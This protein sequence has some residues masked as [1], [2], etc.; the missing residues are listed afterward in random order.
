MIKR[1]SALVA[2]V[3]VAAVAMPAQAIT[4]GVPDDGAHPYVGQLFFYVPDEVDP[5]FTD[6]GSYFTCSGTLVSPTIVLT[7]GHCTYG[8]GRDGRSTI[9]ANGGKGG[10]DV[11]VSFSEVPD[12]DGIPLS[13][14]YVEADDNQGRYDDRVAWFNS[15][16][17][18]HR[19]RAYPHPE[20]EDALFFL[21]DLGVVVLDEPVHM[22]KYGELPELHYLNAF[23]RME[24]SQRRFTPVGYGL[25]KVLPIGTEGGDTRRRANVKL[26]TLKG[27][28]T[29]P[30]GTYATF[31]NNLGTVHQG[32]T[33][34]GDSGGPIFDSGT[35][36]IVAVNSFGVSPNC[37]GFGGG[38]RVDQ[39]DDLHWLARRF[40]IE[41]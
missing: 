40:G 24:K 26:I 37:T 10:N 23:M 22:A 15:N 1:L 25:E 32:G 31:S 9:E 12:Y 33:C 19:G 5:R 30:A 3:M 29:A 41:P 11:W 27:Q 14:D 21:H 13:A 28:G 18:W 38:Y 36:I 39:P 6:P 20:Y 2:L 34:F 17:D 35:R 4:N 7:A 8:I 16:P